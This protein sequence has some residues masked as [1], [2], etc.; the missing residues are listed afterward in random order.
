M[1]MVTKKGWVVWEFLVRC[2]KEPRFPNDLLHQETFIPI[3]GVFPNEDDFKKFISAEWF[4]EAMSEIIYSIKEA[5]GCTGYSI[6]KEGMSG[7]N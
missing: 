4:R 7:D 1:I 5:E 6:K 2:R 3:V